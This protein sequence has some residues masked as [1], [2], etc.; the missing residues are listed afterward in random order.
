MSWAH[1]RARQETPCTALILF[2][3][4]CA[5]PVCS[6][7]FSVG[8]VAGGRGAG[9]QVGSRLS[10]MRKASAGGFIKTQ[11]NIQKTT[12]RGGEDKVLRLDTKLSGAWAKEGARSKEWFQVASKLFSMQ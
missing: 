10:S 12:Q 8:L 7:G 1:L 4:L 3:S 6:W 11:C 5:L 2:I 9:L